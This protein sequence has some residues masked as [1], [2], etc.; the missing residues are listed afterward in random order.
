MRPWRPCKRGLDQQGCSFWG[1]GSAGPQLCAL[2]H[3]QSH[4]STQQSQGP[5]ACT[6][7]R[8]QDSP[9]QCASMPSRTLCLQG[10]TAALRQ[11]RIELSSI[12]PCTYYELKGMPKRKRILSRW[13]KPGRAGRDSAENSAEVFWLPLIR[14]HVGMHRIETRRP[15]A[16]GSYPA[17]MGNTAGAQQG[18]ALTARPRR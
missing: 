11:S 1:A 14:L 4:L 15:H 2:S 9:K 16:E 18:P 6:S 8:R 7:C 13:G 10:C 3:Q 5:G 17:L 12:W